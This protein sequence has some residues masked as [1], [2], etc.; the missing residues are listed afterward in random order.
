MATPILSYYM[1][2]QCGPSRPFCRE[3]TNSLT[4]KNCGALQCENPPPSVICVA[5]GFG[6]PEAPPCVQFCKDNE[7]PDGF[8][9]TLNIFGNPSGGII[10]API[11]VGPILMRAT[12]RC[13]Y[14]AEF[15]IFDSTSSHRTHNLVLNL[16][17]DV[18][19]AYQLLQFNLISPPVVAYRYD[20][21]VN[22][23][24]GDGCFQILPM[25]SIAS[26]GPGGGAA[27]CHPV[28][29]ELT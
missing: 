22:T 1:T 2:H 17:E 27:E 25:I 4:V 26:I 29:D 9:A 28:V 24:I 19:G 6:L 16:T 5:P 18:N 20:S 10:T 14:F 3:C 12:G 8:M 13:S 21:H 11:V 15:N 7:A 23:K